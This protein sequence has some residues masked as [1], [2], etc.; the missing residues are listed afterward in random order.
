ML[1]ATMVFLHMWGEG[2]AVIDN[3]HLRQQIKI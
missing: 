1:A 3:T 2:V